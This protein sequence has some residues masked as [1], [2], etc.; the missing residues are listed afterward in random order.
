MLLEQIPLP[1]SSMSE[2]I[3]CEAHVSSEP[4]GGSAGA[5]V[6]HVFLF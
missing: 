4:L 5:G 3:N 2:H 1:L 6:K